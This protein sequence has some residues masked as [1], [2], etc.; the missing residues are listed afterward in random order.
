MTP[1]RGIAAGVAVLVVA[2]VAAAA[3]DGSGSREDPIRR[4]DEAVDA[5]LVLR[6]S[7]MSTLP[8]LD[9]SPD[10]ETLRTASTALAAAIRAARPL[11]AEG[12]IFNPSAAVVLRRRIRAMLVDPRCPLAEILAV[13]SDD[14]QRL[15]PPRAIVH[16]RFDWSRGSF[17]PSCLLGVLPVLP[18]ELQFRF[19]QRDL[20]LVDID[21]DL[22]VDV[23][24]DA[25]PVGE[26]WKGVHYAASILPDRGLT[27]LI[28]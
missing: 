22:I 21:A 12:D 6:G 24:A 27:I 9:M 7:L 5:Y 10:L 2:A 3:V 8:P 13:E 25:L 15:L 1:V 4:F 17:M 26:S 19:V 11:A 23:L 18:D 20:V 14:E 28:A 16:D